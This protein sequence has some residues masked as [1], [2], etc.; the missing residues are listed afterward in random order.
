M[1]R[2]EIPPTG[3]VSEGGLIR[4]RCVAHHDPVLRGTD[5]EREGGFEIRLLEACIHTARVS[6]LELCVEVNLV[7]DRIHKSVDTLTGA[8][9]GAAR[10]HDEDVVRLDVVQTDPIAVED[11]TGI[12]V[13]SVETDRRHLR[14]DQINPRRIPRS[15]RTEGNRRCR[16]E[17]VNSRRQ[18]KVDVVAVDAD[19]AAALG[20]LGP[21]EVFSHADILADGRPTARWTGDPGA[22]VASGHDDIDPG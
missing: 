18:I 8:H 22:G 15:L 21:G 17:C 12:K 9:V 10:P 7:V 4:A 14:R 13:A 19:K 16:G 1:C 20:S 2:W 3:V 5:M 6:G 11:V